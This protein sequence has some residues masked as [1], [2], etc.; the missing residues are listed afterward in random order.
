M[1]DKRPEPDPL[2]DP[3]QP[4]LNSLWH[5]SHEST[6]QPPINADERR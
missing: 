4:D 1:V 5:E 3:A 6:D 2:H